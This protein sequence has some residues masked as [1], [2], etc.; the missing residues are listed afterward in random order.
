M[1]FNA[2]TTSCWR[3][4]FSCVGQQLEVDVDV[5]AVHAGGGQRLV[6]LDRH[7]RRVAVAQGGPQAVLEVDRCGVVAGRLE[8]GDVARDGLLG[9]R[10]R[11]LMARWSALVTPSAMGLMLICRRPGRHRGLRSSSSR[12]T[13]LSCVTQPDMSRFGPI[14]KEVVR[15]N[16]RAR[17]RGCEEGRADLRVDAQRAD[18]GDRART[19]V[20]RRVG[21]DSTER[22]SPNQLGLRVAP[23]RGRVGAPA[24]APDRDPAAG[25]RDR[26]TESPTGSVA[27][28]RTS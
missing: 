3:R 6:D 12:T 22:T 17:I 14:R 18:L 15:R 8:V 24:R 7:R 1:A 9:A 26:R 28:S 11:P 10:R 19:A 20:D 16:S 23:Y 2:C 21:D 13:V 25:R 27:S 5:V 4:L